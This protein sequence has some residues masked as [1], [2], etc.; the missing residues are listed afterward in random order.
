MDHSQINDLRS[1]L[2]FLAERPGQLVSTD[3]EV[4]PYL[5]IAGI[6]RRVGSGTP[7]APPT[8][9]GPAMMFNKIKRSDW[10]VLAGL[11][12]SRERTA[13]MMG[14]TKERLMFDLYGALG[15]TV[16]PVTVPAAQAPCQEVVVKAPFDLRT[17]IPAIQSTAK[18][19]G[20]F[21][22]LGLLRAEDPETGISDVTIH[23]MCVQGPD[24]ISVSISVGRH[25]GAFLEKAWAMGKSLPASCS[26]GLDPA[27]LVATS[28]EAPTTPLG[29]D[30]LTIAGGLRG[31]PVQLVDCVTQPTKAIARAELVLE[32]EFRLNDRADE[33]ALTGLGWAMPEFPGYV[34]QAQK[35]LAVFTVTGITRRVDP[36][37]QILVGPGEEH[38]TL[39]GLPTE[40]SIY[41][42]IEDAIPGFCKNVYCASAGGGKYLA[43]LQVKK[44]KAHDEGMQKQ[45]ALV[46]FTAFFELKHVI[47]VDDDIDIFDLMDVMWA[48]TTRYQG[49]I[50]TTFIPA[51]RG[52]ALDP[53]ATPEFNQLLRGPGI[54]CKTIFDCTVPWG[55]EER[56]TRSQFVDVDLSKYDIK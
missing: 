30:E 32:G 35:D 10:R 25:I 54:T 33:D 42:L 48:M 29:F 39:T 19:A 5:E 55:L 24:R 28:F 12:A 26:I 7:T 21:F 50:D 14:S 31:R 20:S 37:L 16:P 36:I 40:T 41:R 49:D 45:A 51:T 8:K 47:V 15:N 22:N 46:A 34:G 23:R 18:D 11:L 27:V 1:A 6:Y 3:V 56:F 38:V 52:H 9:I 4:D 43:I 2:D 44:R 13:L 53:S 17:Y